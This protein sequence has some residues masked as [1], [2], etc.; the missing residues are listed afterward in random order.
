VG[1]MGEVPFSM[2][3]DGDFLTAEAIEKIERPRFPYVFELPSSGKAPPRLTGGDD[4]Y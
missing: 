2:V 1:G 4:D 3:Q